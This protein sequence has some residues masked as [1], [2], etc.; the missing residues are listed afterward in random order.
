[1]GVGVP[2]SFQNASAAYR[3]AG[4][5]PVC[6][7]AVLGIEP[8]TSR[9]LSENHT[10][11]PN[12]HCNT[13]VFNFTSRTQQRQQHYRIYNNE[14]DISEPQPTAERDPH[15]P[16]SGSIVHRCVQTHSTSEKSR[17]FEKRQKSK[18]LKKCLSTEKRQRRY[19]VEYSSE[20]SDWNA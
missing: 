12:N 4:I 10:T 14:A 2:A 15:K 1:M 13:L 6:M 11:R 19:R 5:P 16:Q 8:R 20:V 9:T 18:R 17:D 7:R 3:L